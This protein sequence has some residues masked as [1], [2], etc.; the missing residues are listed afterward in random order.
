MANRLSTAGAAKPTVAV[1]GAAGHTGRFVVT[2]LSRRGFGVIAIGRDPAKL[3]GADFPT[4]VRL[5]VAGLEDPASLARALRGA[6]AVV[7]CAGPFLDTAEPL[8]AAALR[9]GIHYLDVTA[10]QAS[11]LAIFDRCS[12][13][14]QSAG[15][16]VIPAMGFYGGLADLLATAAMG[17]WTQADEAR[18]GIALDSW[19][20]TEGTRAT[21]RRNTAGRL[22]LS[23]GRLQSLADPAPNILWSFAGPFGA[24][25]M[26]ELPFTEAILIGLHLK[27]HD[28]HTYLNTAPLR[29]LRDATTPP[30]AP[31]DASGR[32]AQTFLVEVEVRQG[33]A[34]RR[35]SAAGRDIYAITAPLVVEAAQRILD[36]RAVPGGVFAPGALFD[37]PD[38]LAT[39]GFDA[40]S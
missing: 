30:P 5:E 24:Q 12:E 4:G 6:D 7:N 19:K 32:S 40:L 16:V 29:D 22:T 9:A 31:A 2:E 26:V 11:A 34:V 23:E 13:A 17:D 15:V 35:A 1:Y 14:A 37:A 8:V 33:S 10:E 28:L 3:A 21:G 18:I 27:V 25:E 36:D 20:P 39:I 38:F